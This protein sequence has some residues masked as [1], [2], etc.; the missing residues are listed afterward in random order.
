MFANLTQLI[1]G[2]PSPAAVQD[3]FVQ[4]VRTAT[5]ERRDPRVERL[6]CG[7]WVLIAVKHVLIIWAVVHYHVPIHQLWINF[8]TWLLGVLATAI[9]YGRTRR[10]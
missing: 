8:P 2:Q 10:A 6:I 3:A 7:C 4:E 9:Y 1:A 5:A